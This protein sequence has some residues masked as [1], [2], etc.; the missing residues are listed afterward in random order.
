MKE[1]QE[2]LPSLV[3]SLSEEI[4]NASQKHPGYKSKKVSDSAINFIIS[5]PWLG[6]I[7]ELWNRFNRAFIETDASAITA[8]N[9]ES[10]MLYRD[11]KADE[12][13]VVFSLG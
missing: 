6:N 1:R 10:A 5:M 12:D 7:H 2:D 4:N 3:K 13:D 11:S 9:I 8:D